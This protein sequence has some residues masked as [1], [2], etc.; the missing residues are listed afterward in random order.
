MA[1]SKSLV[2]LLIL[3][4]S[5]V[6]SVNAQQIIT[7]KS[8]QSIISSAQVIRTSQISDIP[9]YVK[10]LPGKETSIE[11]TF[12]LLKKVYR[13]NDN[14]T[15]NLLNQHTDKLGD[16]HYRFQQMYMGRPVETGI[17]IFHTRNDMVYA[18]NGLVFN[19]NN[20][21]SSAGI[22]QNTA[23]ETAKNHVNA[24]VYKWEIQAEEDHLK[25]ELSDQS[26][27]Y[28]PAAELVYIQ[29]SLNKKDLKLAYKLNIYAHDPVS[30]AD[31]YVDA[32]SNEIIF[33]NKI[34]KHIDVPGT[35]TTGYSG[36][37]TITT[38]STSAN[39][40]RLRETGRGNGI[41]TYD[42]NQG[43]SYGAANDFTDSDNNWNNVNANLDQYAT[44]AHWGSEV[45]YDYYHLEHG[46]NSIDNAGFALKN[47][48]HYDINYNNAFWDG[49][50]MTFGDGNGFSTTPLVALDISGHEVT[51]GLTNFTANLIYQGESGALNESFSDIFGTCIEN[52]GR[53]QNWNWTVGED[54]G[55]TIRSM[56]NPGSYN[57][58][59]TYQGTN[60]SSTAVGA[61]DNGGV[62]SNSGVQ[63]Y[64]FY[65][66]TTGGTGVNDNGDS[67]SVSGQGFTKA[68]EIAFRNLTVYLSVNSSFSDARYYSIQSAIDLFGPCSPEVEATTNAW[69]AVGVGNAYVNYVL[70]DFTA[71]DTVFCSAP[72]SVSFQ[73]QSINGTSFIWD[74]GD[75]SAT[76]TNVN[77][78]HNYALQGNY[79]VKLIVDGG[80]CGTDTLT[81]S[82][83]IVID[84]SL[85]CVITM[86]DNG[87]APT[88]TACSG[89]LFDSGGNNGN[90]GNQQDSEI[91]ISPVGADSIR[92]DFTAFSVEQGNTANC[93][94]D[95]LDVFDGNTNTSPLI[96]RYCNNNP[97]P[98]FV[99][100]SGGSLTLVF[101]SDQFLTLSGFQLNWQCFLSVLPPVTHFQSK[102]TITCSGN[103]VFSDLSSNGPTS[104][105]WDFGDGNTSNL[106]NPVHT[107]LA[108]GFYDVKL[109]TTNNNGADSLT[110]TNYVEVDFI[111]APPATGD[112]ICLNESANLVANAVNTAKWYDSQSGGNEVATGNVF[113]TSSL[114]A[115]TTYYVS[116]YQPGVIFN[117]GAISNAIGA[118]GFFNGNQSL[119][120]SCTE[121]CTLRTVDV[122]A[123]SAG[124]RTIELR[125]SSGQVLESIT[126]NIPSGFQT[127]TLNLSI[128][129]GTDLEIGTLFGSNPG[130]YRNSNGAI[131]P[132]TSSNGV[133]SITGSTASSAPTYY[134]F[135]YNWDVQLPGCESPRTAVEANI[136]DDYDLEITNVPEY[137]CDFQTAVQLSSNISNGVWS[138]NCID[139]IDSL[140]GIFNPSQSG[141]GIWTI[142]YTADFNCE[143][144]VET[145]IS[146][147]TCLSVDENII[148]QINIFP[149]PGTD[150]TTVIANPEIIKTI[151]ITD[152]S[153]KTVD[154]FQVTNSKTQLDISRYENGLYFFNFLNEKRT[155]LSI[156]KFIKQ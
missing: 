79:D 63:N 46:R 51:H 149:N 53:P 13:I 78:I 57:D 130:L 43:T 55:V 144:T 37:K 111:D 154:I 141:I 91:T 72:A 113:T 12:Q 39:N 50:R 98:A 58:P 6:F 21:P 105:S 62:H 134:Y 73:N 88:Q 133:I 15:F 48:I 128:P 102:D 36:V 131:F 82:S 135:F 30:R 45:T 60:W 108:D 83:Y 31:L 25:D 155:R 92:L 67:Y 96:G 41:E 11:A 140:T 143:K 32:I 94:Y 28:F 148:D 19:S 121:A 64:W 54:I 139:C 8:A 95:Y 38:D 89:T 17:I 44:D 74:F 129:V 3:T 80:A 68:S 110:L 146:V 117:A 118:G 145:T 81:L 29:P 156:E 56:S 138:A 16:D 114:T 126:L 93:N 147:E 23:F 122:V 5:V 18:Y 22:S 109:V 123:N 112:S 59:D 97:P 2:V 69:Y 103:V 106:Q 71:N 1:F 77:P 35:A 26:A 33:E 85:P 75:G 150:I 61:P 125:N 152:V 99:M 52:Y 84:N 4:F 47:Y 136:Y 24:N 49:Q 120:F 119:I 115:D 104:W 76:S 65:L 151:I 27:T 14:Y 137:T 10:F 107:Y 70:S 86:P 87:T 100:S 42:M 20:Q 101:H 116:D 7:G 90:Y 40:Y 132:Y 66:L 142:S 127:I 9:A 34:I 124:N 153:G